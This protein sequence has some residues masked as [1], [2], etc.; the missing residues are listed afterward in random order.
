MSFSPEEVTKYIIG[1]ISSID[2]PYTP[3]QKGNIAV[4]NYLEKTSK[5]DVQSERDEILST[6]LSDIKEMKKMMADVLSKNAFCV[7]GN[8][9]KIQL[10]K[11]LFGKTETL[12]R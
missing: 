11:D 4:K 9:E 7:Y 10:Q 6:T 12:S 1:T 2:N 5:E 8:E 3:S